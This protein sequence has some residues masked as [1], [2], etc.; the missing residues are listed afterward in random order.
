MKNIK[1]VQAIALA[2]VLAIS[3]GSLA[4]CDDTPDGGTPQKP[5]AAYSM[6]IADQV[7]SWKKTT[8]NGATYYSA[9]GIA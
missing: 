7:K 6:N 4:A 8:K 9:E 2:A 1:K 5:S 3:L